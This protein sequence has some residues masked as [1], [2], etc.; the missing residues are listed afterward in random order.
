MDNREREE[1]GKDW[2]VE[3]ADLSRSGQIRERRA[4]SWGS[5]SRPRQ[6]VWRLA[7]AAGV[8][9]LV[10]LVLVLNVYRHL[11]PQQVVP[12][13]PP[14]LT[15]R[16]QTQGMTCLFDAAWSPQG[17]RIALLGAQQVY[18]PDNTG[19]SQR[20]GLVTVY[21]ASAGKVLATLHPDDA[22][23]SALQAFLRGLTPGR[24][25]P[26]ADEITQAS[27]YQHVLWSP[28]GKRLAL[29]FAFDPS[30]IGW[31]GYLPDV[32]PLQRSGVLFAHDDGT[33]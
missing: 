26:P 31:N 11:P 22:T 5:S 14:P 25:S 3:V 32:E 29:T 18:C 24:S 2:E 20:A 10:L 16:P 15:L 30:L 7:S 8:S 27:R 21:D 12:R 9:A 13:R 17:T 33:N 6:W 1:S 4:Q 28:D 19:T 23:V